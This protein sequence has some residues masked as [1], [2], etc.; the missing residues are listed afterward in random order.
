MN[1]EVTLASPTGRLKIVL[2]G[3]QLVPV[4]STAS[5]ATS[6]VALSLDV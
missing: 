3:V 5:V 4:L 6:L 1:L 2:P